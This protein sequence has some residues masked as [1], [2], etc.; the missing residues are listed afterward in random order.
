MDKIHN[1]QTKKMKYYASFS[2]NNNSTFPSEPYEYT[3]KAEAIKKIKKIVRGNHF[4]Q[5]FNRSSYVVW[6]SNG[7]IIAS[8]SIND[9]GWWS[10]DKDAIGD[11]INQ[12]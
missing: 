6:T 7:V 5:R 11:N 10:V 2:A 3:N 1:K 9:L 4:W 12:Y 8:G